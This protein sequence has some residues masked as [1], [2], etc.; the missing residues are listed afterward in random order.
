VTYSIP[1]ASDYCPNVTIA[2]TGGQ[3][4]GSVFGTGVSTVSYRATDAAGNFADCSFTI[5]VRD[6]QAPNAV[7]KN[8]TALLSAAGTVTV[9]ASQVNGGSTDNCSPTASLQFTPASATYTCANVGPNDY[10]LTVRDTSGNV[11]TCVATVTVRDVT[12][13][14]ITSC[15][16][17]ITYNECFVIVPSLTGSVVA[18]DNCGPVTITQNPVA[19]VNTSGGQITFTATDASGNTSTCAAL[20]VLND[21]SAVRITCPNN[22]VVSNDVDQCGANVIYLL[23]GSVRMVVTFQYLVGFQVYR[24]VPSSM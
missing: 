8:V 17:N 22:L 6:M 19:G 13:P 18:T 2:R 5:R 12:A 21:T 15:P 10:V 23:P 7:C 11:S 4:S 1:V 9:S 14:T 20:L 24:V 3:A 16:P